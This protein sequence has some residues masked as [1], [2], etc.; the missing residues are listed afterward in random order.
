II[1]NGDLKNHYENL[2]KELN[3]ADKLVFLASLDNQELKKYYSSCDCFIFPSLT[4]SEAF[5]IV[6]IEAMASSKPVIYS[7]LPGV[8]MVPID[9]QTGFLFKSG[10]HKDLKDKIEKLFNGNLLEFSKNSRKRVE[11]N[12]NELYLT[13]KLNSIY[14]N[15]YN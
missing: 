14:E 8:R 2:A 1:G 5:G 7:D 12:F 9:G 11:E 10:D 15:L 3:I 6:Q 4:R 13:K